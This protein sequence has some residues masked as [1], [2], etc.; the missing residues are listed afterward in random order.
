MLIIASKSS[1]SISCSS[2]VPSLQ[3]SQIKLSPYT[4]PLHFIQLGIMFF[5]LFQSP[6]AASAYPTGLG[7]FMSVIRDV[8]AGIEPATPD[9]QSGT[10][11]LSY[12]TICKNLKRAAH[13]TVIAACHHLE[14]FSVR[15]TATFLHLRALLSALVVLVR[16]YYSHAPGSS[17]LCIGCNWAHHCCCC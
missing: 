12:R 14:L 5:F 6:K 2:A 17:D 3:S 15:L 7:L 13:F 10:L 4:G 1:S 11:P 16:D 9:L 8:R